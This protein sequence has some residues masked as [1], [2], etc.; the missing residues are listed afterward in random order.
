MDLD[1][2]FAGPYLS[3]SYLQI[4]FSLGGAVTVPSIGLDQRLRQ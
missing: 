3:H 2:G 1:S 4:L